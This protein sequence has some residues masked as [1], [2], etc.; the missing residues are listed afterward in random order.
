MKFYN[1]R[2]CKRK[3]SDFRLYNQIILLFFSTRLTFL[4]QKGIS[5]FQTR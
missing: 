5:L 1:L 3:I 4:Q 2:F